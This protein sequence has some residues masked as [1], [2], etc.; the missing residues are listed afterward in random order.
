MT[1]HWP[2]AFEIDHNPPRSTTKAITSSQK[3]MEMEQPC[4]PGFR[5]A[6]LDVHTFF[7]QKMDNEVTDGVL[8]KAV[9]SA[10]FSPSLRHPTLMLVGEPPA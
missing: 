7:R 5:G 4:R 6:E 9:N 3:G 10:D 2:E 1:H 8:P